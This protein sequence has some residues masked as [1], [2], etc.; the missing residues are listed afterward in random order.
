MKNARLRS[1]SLVGSK[2][3]QDKASLRGL[4]RASLREPWELRKGRT[5]LSLRSPGK[6][7]QRRGHVA[8]VLKGKQESAEERAKGNVLQAERHALF[9]GVGSAGW[10]RTC[11]DQ[12]EASER[13]LG[14]LLAGWTLS[15]R[16]CGG[17]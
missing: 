2:Q 10:P 14:G 1:H 3:I 16:G 7:F 8:P 5:G 13:F 6:P 11:S 15:R 4:E 12:S 17:H 9:R